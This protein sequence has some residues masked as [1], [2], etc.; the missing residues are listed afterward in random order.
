MEV[1]P[2]SAKGLGSERK[3]H[4]PSGRGEREQKMTMVTMLRIKYDKVMTLALIKV[5][6]I[7]LD[8]ILCVGEWNEAVLSRLHKKDK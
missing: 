4:T 3:T 1:D 6:R 5:I 2:L 7:S 8:K